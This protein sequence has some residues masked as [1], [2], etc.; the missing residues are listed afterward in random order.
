MNQSF[1]KGENF[2]FSLFPV[3]CNRLLQCVIAAGIIVVS[4]AGLQSPQVRVDFGPQTWQAK[5][6]WA[7]LRP[8]APLYSYAAVSFSNVVATTCQYEAL[9]Y[10]TFPVQTLGK[11]GKM[12]PVMIWGMLILRKRYQVKD[13]AVA[14]A[15]TAGCAMF[16]LTGPFKSKRAPD[17]ND[18][19]LFG[20]LLMLG[21]LMFDGFTSTFQDKLFSGYHMTTFN[22]VLYVSMWS[23]ILSCSGGWVG[24]GYPTSYNT[25]GPADLPKFAA[26][27]IISGS[28]LPAIAFAL[29]NPDAL[30]A[31]AIIS[32]AATSGTPHPPAPHHAALPYPIDSA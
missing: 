22:Q 17:N 24:A 10:L 8:V 11:C 26:G 23:A 9:K 19:G 7:A 4:G 12:F 31:I 20:G 32:I 29:R 2:D 21:Y 5:R 30:A 15:I 1:G 18:A 27:L 13:F 25:S 6:D 14:V 16:I 3:L 28:L